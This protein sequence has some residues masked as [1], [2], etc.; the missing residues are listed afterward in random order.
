M[1]IEHFLDT[2]VRHKEKQGIV[3]ALKEDPARGEWSQINRTLLCAE[4]YST[5]GQDAMHQEQETKAEVG[6]RPNVKY[7]G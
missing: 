2:N 6:P 4:T 1:S 7:Q 3:P 5:V